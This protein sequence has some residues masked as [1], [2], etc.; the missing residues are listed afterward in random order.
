MGSEGSRDK[1]QGVDEAI[2]EAIWPRISGCFV[3]DCKGN[4]VFESD[5]SEI[6][7]SYFS[8]DRARQIGDAI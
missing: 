1:I 8:Y 3:C 2:Y 4:L 7:F 5:D 6:L